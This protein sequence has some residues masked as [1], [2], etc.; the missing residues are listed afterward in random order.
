MHDGGAKAKVNVYY[1]GD[2][3]VI[4]KTHG[5]KGSSVEKRRLTLSRLFQLPPSTARLPP[6]RL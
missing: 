3:L 4:L 2:A 1:N 6:T 5:R